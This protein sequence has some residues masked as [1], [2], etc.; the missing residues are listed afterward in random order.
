M[1]SFLISLGWFLLF[2]GGAIY[3]AYH[4]VGLR[5]STIAAGAALIAYTIYGDGHFLWLLALWLGFGVLVVPNMLEFRRE[6]LTRPALDIYRTLLPSMSD[7]EREAL[8]AGNVW[9]DG[10]LFFRHARL[11]SAHVLP[12]AAIVGRR[13]GVPGW[14]LR[15]AVRDAGRLGRF[16]RSVSTCRRKRGPILKSIAFSR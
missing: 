6:K 1:S 12:G 13:A 9:W 8:E 15:R 2:F 16:A 5:T 14:T 11:G 4:R 10:E 7:T 3:L